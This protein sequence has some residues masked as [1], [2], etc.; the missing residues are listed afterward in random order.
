MGVLGLDPPLEHVELRRPARP[1]KPS[2]GIVSSQPSIHS[3]KGCQASA[4]RGSR[5]ARPQSSARLTT[6]SGAKKKAGA[7]PGSSPA[8][9][10][11][12]LPV[13]GPDGHAVGELVAEVRVDRLAHV[14]VAGDVD[15]GGG[16]ALERVDLVVGDGAAVDPQPF[17]ELGAARRGEPDQLDVLALGEQEGGGDR[18]LAR[19]AGDR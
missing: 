12:L 11:D 3:Q 4:T 15:V 7:G 9:G 16:P 2:P 19:G 10:A 18:G 14:A 5:P 1:S 17:D 8:P 13:G 6:R